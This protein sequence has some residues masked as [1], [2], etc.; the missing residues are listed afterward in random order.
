MNS[1]ESGN[2]VGSRGIPTVRGHTDHCEDFDFNSGKLLRSSEQRNA[3]ECHDL[4]LSKLF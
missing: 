3:E 4:T 2:R 1:G